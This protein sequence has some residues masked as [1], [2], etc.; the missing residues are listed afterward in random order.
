MQLVIICFLNFVMMS[1]DSVGPAGLKGSGYSQDNA[2]ENAEE[3]P[4]AQLTE[5]N[6]RKGANSSSELLKGNHQQIQVA[7]DD[8]S[9]RILPRMWINR[10]CRKKKLFAL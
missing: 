7:A 3:Q 2:N 8:T 10:I 5:D 1:C 9:N 4:D 6:P